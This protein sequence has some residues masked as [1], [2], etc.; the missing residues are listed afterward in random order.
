[1]DDDCAKRI[2]DSFGRSVTIKDDDWDGAK[3]ARQLVGALKVEGV[4]RQT[5]SG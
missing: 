5:L 4:I 2:I 1:M 3:P